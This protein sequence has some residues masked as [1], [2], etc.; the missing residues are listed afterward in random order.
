MLVS[1]ELY[2]ISACVNQLARRLAGDSPRGFRDNSR[3]QADNSLSTNA[4]SVTHR[5]SSSSCSS[6]PPS[7]LQTLAKRCSCSLQPGGRYSLGSS[8]C[9]RTNTRTTE[10]TNRPEGCSVPCPFSWTK[11]EVS[12]LDTRNWTNVTQ[13]MQVKTSIFVTGLSPAVP[14]TWKLNFSNL[15]F[16][17]S[18]SWSGILPVVG[19]LSARR[20]SYHSLFIHTFSLK[21]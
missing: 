5:R 16:S 3:Q 10:I 4:H 2:N 9:C 7:A 11:G 13:Q 17:P 1:C 19:L 15:C 14:V 21:L 20:H 8:C 18:W 6:R 12:V